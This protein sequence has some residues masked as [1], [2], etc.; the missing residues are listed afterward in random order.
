MISFVNSTDNWPDRAPIDPAGWRDAPRKTER[1]LA[2]QQFWR[3]GRPF[4]DPGDSG[5]GVQ[6]DEGR[7]CR[8]P[9][10]PVRVMVE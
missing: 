10:D 7:P 2:D 8:V 3:R 4:A 9:A 1:I 6:D 5:V